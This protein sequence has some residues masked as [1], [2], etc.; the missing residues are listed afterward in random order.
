MENAKMVRDMYLS[1]RPVVNQRLPLK[2][3]NGG[4]RDLECPLK[5][6]TQYSLYFSQ[7]GSLIKENASLKFGGTSNSKPNSPQS[8]LQAMGPSMEDEN[9]KLRAKVL[10]MEQAKPQKVQEL[11]PP[12]KRP[13][14]HH[15]KQNSTLELLQ[16]FSK[17]VEEMEEKRLKKV[18]KQKE[19]STSSKK[20]P[21]GEDLTGSRFKRIQSNAHLDEE[22]DVSPKALILAAIMVQHL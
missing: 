9:R 17:E 13:S 11:S 6:A 19:G 16:R 15:Q 12:A 5:S 22:I 7:Y 1:K 8:W 3:L 18:R 2:Y 14:S 21:K 4:N 20:L 10:E